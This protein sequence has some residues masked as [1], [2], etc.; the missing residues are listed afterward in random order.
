M[1][2][3]KGYRH[4]GP[5][6]EYSVDKDGKY[7]DPTNKCNDYILTHGGYSSNTSQPRT[8]VTVNGMPYNGC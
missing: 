5:Y 6:F 4:W 8:K 1:D 3:A 2:Y 7:K